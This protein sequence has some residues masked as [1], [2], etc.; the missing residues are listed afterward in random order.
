M[1]PL[2]TVPQTINVV[3]R[4]VIEQQ[5]VNTLRDAL[6]N[7]AGISLAAGEGGSQGDNLTIRG[8]SARNDLFIDGIR[9]FGSYYRTLSPPRRSRCCRGRR[10]SPSDEARRAAW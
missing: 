2:E 7:V 4:Q 6:R 3:P 10:R 8:C 9:D 5:G 1:G